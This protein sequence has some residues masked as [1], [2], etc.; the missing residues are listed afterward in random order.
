[1]GFDATLKVEKWSEDIAAVEVNKAVR[2]EFWMFVDTLKEK[3][4][5]YFRIRIDRPFKPKSTGPR[6]QM[7]R[8]RGHCE[9]ISVQLIELG[10]EITPEEVAEAMKRMSVAEGYGTHLSIDGIEM[11][12][13]LE[14]A[15]MEQMAV[16]L[17]VQA[18]YADT[19]NF[20]LTE[21]NDA[22]P[23]VPYKSVGGRTEKEMVYYWERKAKK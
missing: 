21:Y 9:D 20:W 19:N 12:N 14:G 13:S 15:S 6:S 11:P 16:V 8:F 1:M 7:A 10:Q 23:P 18:R 4:N 22:T 2:S 3:T 17:K 5:G